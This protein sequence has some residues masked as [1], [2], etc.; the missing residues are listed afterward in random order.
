MWFNGIIRFL[1]ISFSTAVRIL[2]YEAFL[3]LLLKTLSVHPPLKH[4]L[5]VEDAIFVF[6][7]T[8]QEKWACMGERASEWPEENV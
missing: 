2:F 1:S 3:I 4:K 5:S 6:E 8:L 7:V